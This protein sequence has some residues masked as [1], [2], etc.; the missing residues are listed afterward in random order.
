MVVLEMAVSIEYIA[1]SILL[2]R[3]TNRMTAPGSNKEK[4]Q[5][6][7]ISTGC[8]HIIHAPPTVIIIFVISVALHIVT[9]H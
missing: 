1:I 2:T 8:A 6:F 3:I 7:E 4:S 9:N 5:N